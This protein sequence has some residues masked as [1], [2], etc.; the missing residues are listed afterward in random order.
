MSGSSVDLLLFR[1]DQENDAL[2]V[3][4]HAQDR[5]YRY[6]DVDACS[7]HTCD[8]PD[9]RYDIWEVF[10]LRTASFVLVF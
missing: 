3:H 10:M 4:P 5:I 8:G 7:T 9:R 1:T 6:V 2:V